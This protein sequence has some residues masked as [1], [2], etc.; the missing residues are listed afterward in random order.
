LDVSNL[1]QTIDPTGA[2]FSHDKLEGVTL[3]PGGKLVISNDSDFGIDGLTNSTPPFQLHAKTSPVTGQ[4]DNG[5]FLVIDLAHLAGPVSGTTVT[6]NVDRAT[7]TVT[8]TDAG[9]V[10]TG[11]PFPATDAKVTGVA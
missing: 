4:Q 8:V 9:G 6:I 1:L 7:P 5:E 10:Y 2:F 11:Q 3:L